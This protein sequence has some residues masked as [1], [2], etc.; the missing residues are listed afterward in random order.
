MAVSCLGVD[1]RSTKVHQPAALAAQPSLGGSTWH[2]NGGWH[3]G[4]LQD[5]GVSMRHGGAQRRLRLR[6]VGLKDGVPQWLQYGYG[7]NA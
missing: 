6:Y 4:R 7:S 5:V 3:P 1:G 2:R